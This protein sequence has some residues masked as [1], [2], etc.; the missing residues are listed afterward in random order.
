[1]LKTC[2]SLALVLALAA[3][4]SAQEKPA[5]TTADFAG[6]WNIEVMSHQI[7]LVIEAT[8]GNK[9]TATMMAMGR[10]TPLKGELVDR[11]LTLVAVKTDAEAAA[12]PDPAAAHA[13]AEPGAG[14]EAHAAPAP[15]PIVATLQEDGTL[16]G[17]MMTNAGPVKWT[18]EKLKKRKG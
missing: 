8:D 7:A 9:V 1:M 13:A 3:G 2:S 6:T 4:A 18:A 14:H 12:A 16:T 11:T 17:E 10:D 15:R 5:V